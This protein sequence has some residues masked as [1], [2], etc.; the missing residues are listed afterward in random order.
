MAKRKV[1][2]TRDNQINPHVTVKSFVVYPDAS[3]AN[4]LYEYR[5]F[6]FVFDCLGEIKCNLVGAPGGATRIAG[7][8]AK[9]VCEHA[10][11][12]MLEAAVNEDWRTANAQ[13]YDGGAA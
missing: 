1:L 2:T 4:G 5:G 8:V 10:Y 3:G 9:S 11:L 13:M 7:K 6:R 12:T